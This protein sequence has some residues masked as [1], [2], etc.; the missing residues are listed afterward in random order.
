M[1]ETAMI[2][3]YYLLAVLCAW[4]ALDSALDQAEKR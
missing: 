4:C 2:F 1:E 3:F